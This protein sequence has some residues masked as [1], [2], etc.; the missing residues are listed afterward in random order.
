[1][2]LQ[3]WMHVAYVKPLGSPVFH[4]INQGIGHILTLPV[5]PELDFG[6]SDYCRS[7]RIQLWLQLKIVLEQCNRW[8]DSKKSFTNMEKDRYVEN[9]IQCQVVEGYPIEME[10]SLQK[11][12][13]MATL[14]PA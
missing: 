2:W 9:G 7:S 5:V 11:S 14:I 6:A 4:R 10:Q 13:K 3:W 8:W 12:G 1:M